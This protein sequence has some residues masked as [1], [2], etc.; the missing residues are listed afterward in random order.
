MDFLD[1]TTMLNHY[2]IKYWFL[3]G[4]KEVLEVED[5]ERIFDQTEKK[6]NKLSDRKGCFTLTVPYVVMDCFNI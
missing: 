1:G 5:Q 6:L 2:L 3:A 4:W